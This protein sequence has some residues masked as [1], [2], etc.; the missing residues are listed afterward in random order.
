MERSFEHIAE[1]LKREVTPGQIF[2]DLGFDYFGPIDGH[3]IETLTDIFQNIKNVEG[4][5]LLHVITEKGKGFHP[6]SENPA[7]YHSAGNYQMR[8]WKNEGKTK[9]SNTDQLYKSI[10]RYYN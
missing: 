4:P 7:R 1:A 3:C 2:V 10:W 8:E 5:I 9:G 6:A